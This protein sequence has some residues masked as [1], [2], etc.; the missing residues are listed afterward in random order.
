[1]FVTDTL[2]SQ[3]ERLLQSVE[4]RSRWLTNLSG[5]AD[6]LA[7]D[8]ALVWA[9]ERALHVA[10]ECV[11]DAANLIIDALVMRD[12]GGY[13]D[14]VRVLMEEGVVSRDWFRRFEPM[15][16]FRERLVHGY[17]DLGPDEVVQAVTAYGPLFMEY[18]ESVRRYLGITNPGRG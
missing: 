3:V 18:V 9:A 11:T 1:M 17:Q 14:I 2:R 15:L 10:V 5:Q 16:Q 8:T 4:V 6:N 7:R 13:V 12:P